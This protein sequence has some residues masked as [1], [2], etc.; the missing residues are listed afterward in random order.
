M[1]RDEGPRPKDPGPNARNMQCMQRT[2]RNNRAGPHGHPGRTA[3]D[4]VG[5]ARGD[6]L[7][8]VL[9]SAMLLAAIVIGTLTGLDALNRSTALSR[10]RS[11]ADALAQQEQE[12]LRSEPVA[13]LTELSRTKNVTLN[14]TTFTVKTTSEYINDEK[15]T[16]SCSATTNEADEIKTVSEVTWPTMGAAKPVT[17][18]SLISPPPGTLLIVQVATPTTKVK[19]ASVSVSGS[20]SAKGETSVN[21]CAL[22]NLQSG[23]YSINAF[24]NGYVDPNGYANTNE[25]S[26]VTRVDY[27]V[28]GATIRVG[29]NLAPA[30]SLKI[31]AGP[32]G[33]EA[34]QYTVFNPGMTE[35]RYFGTN[36]SYK[37][38]LETPTTIYPFSS[39]YT[40]YAGTCT[41]DLPTSNGQASNPEV[42]VP[43]GGS[44]E[45]TVPVVPL[46]ISVHSG[47]SE[48]APGEL[49]SGAK[50]KIVDTGCNTSDEFTTSAGSVG[51]QGL[52]FG[53]F[54]FCV[55]A[56]NKKWTGNFEDKSPEGATWTTTPNGGVNASSVAQFYLGTNPSGSPTGVVSG[57]C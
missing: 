52:G 29:Y 8:E 14:G 38:S 22:M 16:A 15:A 28:A 45:V 33:N 27:L 17:E 53:K 39:P 57:S 26:S 21:G 35:P 47:T 25:D 19:G 9:I 20:T 11:Q 2:G 34:D 6:T 43:E 4:I 40:V 37:T 41:A 42:T 7:I 50:V 56:S 44:A 10:D 54:S 24:K 31:K 51:K 55:S 48:K 46:K 36:G 30:G 32:A 1:G 5:Q 49:I 23:E 18:S 12:V 3:F 13:K